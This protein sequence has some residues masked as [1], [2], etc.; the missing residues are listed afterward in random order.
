MHGGFPSKI[1]DVKRQILT[2]NRK[3][4]KQNRGKVCVYSCK[5]ITGAYVHAI[6]ITKNLSKNVSL[7]FTKI[8]YIVFLLLGEKSEYCT[9]E[10]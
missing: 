7:K 1:K 8:Y 5:K 4:I 9:I 6:G 3:V 10:K 2:F